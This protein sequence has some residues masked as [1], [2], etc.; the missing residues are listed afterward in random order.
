MPALKELRQMFMMKKRKLCGTI[1]MNS[2]NQLLKMRMHFQALFH[3]EELSLF[4][5]QMS[6]IIASISTKAEN[7]ES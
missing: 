3:V 6:W 7:D 4:L 5:F 2:V 1:L